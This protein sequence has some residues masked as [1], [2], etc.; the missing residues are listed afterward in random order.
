[1]KITIKQHYVPQFYLRNFGNRLFG[2]DKK[3]DKI[4]PTTSKNIA[5]ESD[6]YGP[7]IKGKESLEK[8]FSEM[9]KKWSIAIAELIRKESFFELKDESKFQITTFM[10][11]QLIRTKQFRQDISGIANSLMD[12]LLENKGIKKGSVKLSQEGE[13]KHHLL[14]LKDYSAFAKILSLMRFCVAINKTHL[15]FWTSDNPINLQNDIPEQPPFGNKGLAC[16][17]IEIHLPITPRLVL[18]AMDPTMYHIIPESFA[19]T[20]NRLIHRENYHQYLNSTRFMFSNTKKFNQREKM[21]STTPEVR[22]PDFVRFSMVHGLGDKN[23]KQIIQRKLNKSKLHKPENSSVGIDTWID[24]DYVE[25][26]FK[27]I[28]SNPN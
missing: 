12:I 11:F 8:I 24:L 17:G 10:A 14:R 6:F 25:S 3:D 21:L 18:T 7:D 23:S 1:M 20:E 9:E 2:F 28:D 27:K 16:R 22:G 26:L 13:I 15:P 4:F 5:F 19:I